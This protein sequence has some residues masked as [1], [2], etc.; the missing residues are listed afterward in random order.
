MDTALIVFSL[1]PCF[2][3]TAIHLAAVWTLVVVC[4][5]V[6]VCV[7]VGGREKDEDEEEEEGGVQEKGRWIERQS[8]D[9]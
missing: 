2:E 5:C 1:L 9:G 3:M 7:C 4:V 6:C 8:R